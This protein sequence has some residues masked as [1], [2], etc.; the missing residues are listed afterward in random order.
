MTLRVKLQ[1]DLSAIKRITTA[2]PKSFSWLELVSSN[3]KGSEV[4]NGREVNL[5]RFH[6]RRLMESD[7]SEFSTH[8]VSNLI[9]KCSYLQLR[10]AIIS[11]N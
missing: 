3:T 6:S 4:T 2:A 8:R 11:T 5:P 10:T 1:T 7:G 9:C